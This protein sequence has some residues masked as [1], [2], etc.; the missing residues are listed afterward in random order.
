MFNKDY[1]TM[2]VEILRL[3][4]NGGDKGVDLYIIWFTP[5]NQIKMI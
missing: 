1:M 3:S 5:N 2:R 4:L